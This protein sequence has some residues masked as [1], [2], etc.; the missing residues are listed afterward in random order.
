MGAIMVTDKVRTPKGEVSTVK[1]YVTYN[2]WE[3]ENGE[4]WPENELELIE[5]GKIWN[6]RQEDE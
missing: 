6:E 3:L 5:V 1:Y 4:R 2:V